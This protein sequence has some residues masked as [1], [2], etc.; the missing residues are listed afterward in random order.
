MV[1]DTM[2]EGTP[3]SKNKASLYAAFE[4]SKIGIKQPLIYIPD[5]S[6]NLRNYPKLPKS[7]P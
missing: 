7:K 4:Q 1:D 5:F 2:I 6:K 3:N